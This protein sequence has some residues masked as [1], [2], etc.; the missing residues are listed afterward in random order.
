MK[1]YLFITLI[2]TFLGGCASVTTQYYRLP[3]SGLPK[4]EKNTHLVALKVAMPNFLNTTSMAYQTDDVTLNFS[5]QN[6]WAD[7]LQ[8]SITQSLINKL[9]KK[10]NVQEYVISQAPLNKNI[11]VAVN[12]FYGRYDGHVTV[13]GFI[14]MT[15]AEGKILKSQNFDFSIAQK[16]DGYAAMVRALDTSLDQLTQTILTEMN[17]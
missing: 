17:E 15:S 4:Q 7:S 9:N 2:L 14:Q 10:T 6:L 8:N 1:K 3:D 11:T 5:Q 13:S 12:R 16:G